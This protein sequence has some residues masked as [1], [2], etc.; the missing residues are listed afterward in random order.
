MHPRRDESDTPVPRVPTLRSSR[1]TKTDVESVD[2]RSVLATIA[3]LEVSEWSYEGDPYGVRHVGPM[4][5]DFHEAFGLG[6]DEE[7]V[8]PLD[9]GGIALA[10]L[11]GVV[12]EI[13]ERDEQLAVRARRIDHLEAETAALEER[14]QAL[15]RTID[16]V[17]PFAGRLEGE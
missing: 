13:E 10:A 5:A 1:S 12:A 15:E 6:K 8:A 9:V 16:E 4:A 3:D 17:A 7:H 14:I 11:Q 2:G